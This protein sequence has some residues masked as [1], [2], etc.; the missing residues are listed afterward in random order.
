MA[1]ILF[2]CGAENIKTNCIE[3]NVNWKSQPLWLA[4]KCWKVPLFSPG[5][6]GIFETPCMWDLAYRLPF[7]LWCCF[8]CDVPGR[9]GLWLCCAPLLSPRHNTV[10][11]PCG[12]SILCAPQPRSLESFPLACHQT[13]TPPAAFL[14]KNVPSITKHGM[15]IT[16]TYSKLTHTV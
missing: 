16:A 14:L 5:L 13:V 12:R 8:L 7:H 4:A 11:G 9:A 10:V 3:I 6:D 1:M 15:I 2:S